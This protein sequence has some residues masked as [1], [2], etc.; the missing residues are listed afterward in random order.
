[1]ST[2]ILGDLSRLETLPDDELLARVR[3]LLRGR[4]RPERVV[5]GEL[6]VDRASRTVTV[7]GRRVPLA[8]K[9]FELL[10]Q[11]ASDPTRVFTKAELLRDVW[12]FPPH[13]RTRTLDS[14]ASRLRRKLSSPGRQYVIN[15]WGVGYKLLDD[16]S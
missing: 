10:A 5:A 14:H 2:A 6:V 4:R 1:M 16:A 11:L 8:A 15:V 7:G 13:C 9:E 3:S 12:D